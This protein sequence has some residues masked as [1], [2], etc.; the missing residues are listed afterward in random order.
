[1]RIQQSRRRHRMPNIDCNDIGAPASGEFENLNI[2]AMRER[3]E[4]QKASKIIGDEL[5]RRWVGR[6]EG[7][8]G[9]HGRGNTTHI[10]DGSE[11]K[12]NNSDSTLKKQL[13]KSKFEPFLWSGRD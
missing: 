6:E 1:M 10:A 12:K 8:L 9:R 7:E 11:P 3:A 13:I 2:F 5:I 4:K